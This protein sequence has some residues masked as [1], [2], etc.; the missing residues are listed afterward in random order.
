M[1]PNLPLYSME[2][3]NENRPGPIAAHRVR[4]LENIGDRLW[5]SRQHAQRPPF[6][7]FLERAPGGFGNVL[8]GLEMRATK[9]LLREKARLDLNP[10]ALLNLRLN[11][12]LPLIRLCETRR[13]HHFEKLVR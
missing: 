3:H 2:D 4:A 9:R 7:R 6:T 12:N 8:H 11:L 5:S 1:S 13:V 10:G